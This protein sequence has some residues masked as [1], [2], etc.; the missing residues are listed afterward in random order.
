MHPAEL[1]P[2]D[3]Q[4]ARCASAHREDHGV[5]IVEQLL[6]AKLG[7][8]GDAG[9]EGDALGAH[10]L[11]AR[12]DDSLLHLEVGDP[13]AKEASDAIVA[14]EQRDVVPGARELLGGREPRRARAH[15]GHS[16][17]GLDARRPGDER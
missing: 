4:V 2:R 17:A 14:L 5:K 10:L 16:L 9:A 13:V 6:A 11:D 3:R 15:D 12:V 1:P 7:A 8:D